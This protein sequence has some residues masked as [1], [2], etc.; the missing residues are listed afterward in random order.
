MSASCKDSNI[1]SCKTCPA[2]RRS[3]FA[4][5]EDSQ[6]ASLAEEKAQLDYCRGDPLSQK[7]QPTDYVYCLRSGGAKVTLVDV[8][9]ARESLVRL[10]G[11]GDLLG[12]RCIFSEDSFRGTATALNDSV[13]CKISKKFVFQLIEKNPKFSMEILR[14][15]GLEVAAAEYHHHSFC[16]KNVRER[17]AEALLILDRK[18]G[19]DSPYG[20]KINIRLTRIELSN[21]VGASRETVIRGLAE[22]IEESLI[23]QKGDFIHIMDIS[24]LLRAS[25]MNYSTTAGQLSPADPDLS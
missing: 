2:W 8:Q 13:A 15:M 12:Y 24:R 17:L 3:P 6:L 22:F 5:L 16:Q 11:P 18:F 14:R 23:C 21:W 9:T 20:R 1:Q 4:D 19:E 25:G 10:A 7:G